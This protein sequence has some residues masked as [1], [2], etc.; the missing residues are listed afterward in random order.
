MASEIGAA[1]S[2]QDY[3]RV[4]DAWT[5][6]ELP[7][8]AAQGYWHA[9]LAKVR[10]N[11]AAMVAVVALFLFLTSCVMAPLYAHLVA[12]INPFKSNLDGTVLIGGKQVPVMQSASNGLGVT[13]VGPTWRFG[14]YMLGADGQGRDV[15]ARLLYGGRVSLLVGAAS[16]VICLSFAV[17]LGIAAGFYGGIINRV[18]SVMLD[19]L[20]AFPIYLLAISLSIILINSGIRIGPLVVHSDDLILP[21]AIIGIIYVP[22]VARPIRAQVMTLRRSDFVMASICL[23][24]SDL[25]ILRREILPNVASTLIVFTPIMMALNIITE[26]SLSFLG[27]GVQPPSASWGTIIRDGEHLLY[28]RPLVSIAPGLAIVITVVAL[29]ILGDALRDALDP[30]AKLTLH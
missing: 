8:S 16:T 7:A 28:T 13:P 19:I 17:L 22:Y 12:H 15:A 14:P 30:R 20:W 10:R 25:R 4:L 27:I 29:N 21:I 3:A 18:I 26:A 6:P 9:A 5:A 1:I 23:G 2:D 24:A 11:R